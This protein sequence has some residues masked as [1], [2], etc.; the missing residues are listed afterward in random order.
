VSS[1]EMQTYMQNVL[2]RDTD[3]MSMASSLEVRVPFLDYKLVEY[4][5][6]IPDS[7]KYP[8]SP[9]KLLIDS[10]NILPD[11]VVNRP[12]MG[13]VLPW[14]LWLKNELFDFADNRIKSLAARS[15]FNEKNILKHWSAF[16]AGDKS[17]SWARLWIFIVLEDYIQKLNLEF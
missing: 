8:H 1:A 7:Y 17:V 4:A 9:K 13:F 12:K 5:Y 16:Q 6:Q 15:F 11:E 3:Q 10:M 14:D 2:L